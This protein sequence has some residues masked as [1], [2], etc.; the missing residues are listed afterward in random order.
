MELIVGRA[1][2]KRNEFE[3]PLFDI[4]IIQASTR[5]FSIYKKIGEG[6]F[7]PVYKV[8]YYFS[9]VNY[10]TNNIWNIDTRL[11]I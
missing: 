7:G 5:N 4:A 10:I 9:F 2:S 1:G 6:G 8:N 11:K 3:L